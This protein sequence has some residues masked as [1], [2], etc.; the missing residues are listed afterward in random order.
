MESRQKHPVL[1]LDSLHHTFKLEFSCSCK[2]IYCQVRVG[3]SFRI[4]AGPIRP[5]LTPGTAIRLRQIFC[6]ESSI[7][8][9]QIRP[10]R[11][12]SPAF[13]LGKPGSIWPSSWTCVN[14]NC[15]HAFPERIDTSLTPEAFHNSV[16]PRSALGWLFFPVQ[17]EANLLTVQAA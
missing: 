3:G 10:E 17:F 2:R 5:Q 6:S 7:L 15:G 13:P 11:A 16:W 8:N 14:K 9:T 1:G 4:D 12:I